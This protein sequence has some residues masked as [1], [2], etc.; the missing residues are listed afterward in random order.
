MAKN[1]EFKII[2]NGLT[3]SI[4]AVDALNKQ[5][6]ALEKRLDT[7]GKKSVSVSASGGGNRAAL[8]EEAKMLQQ[9]EQLHQ[10]V[11][12][13]EKAEYQELLHAK[14][15]LKEYQQIAKSIAAQTNLDQGINNTNTM[16]G[17]KAQLKDLKTAMQ[18]I[19]V[20]SDKFRQM[21]QEANELNTRLKELEQGYGQFGRNVGNYANGVADGMQK[22]VI[23]VGDTARE[24]NNAR[25]ASRTLNMELKSMAL[26]GQQG[27][28][29]YQELNDAVKQM[30]ST[31]K[32]VE[33]SSVAMDNLLDTMQGLTALASAGQGLASLFGIDDSEIEKSIQKMV[34]LQ[35]VLQGIETIRKQMQT[36]EGIGMI[37][38]RG[39]KAVDSLVKSIVGVG[40]ASKGATIAVKLLSGALKGIGIGLVIA[41]VSTL[42]SKITDW[43]EKQEEAKK[44]AEELR[45]ETN[46]NKA[47]LET[48]RLEMQNTLKTLESFNGS[49]KEEERIVKDLNSK[50][51]Q[52]LGTYKTIA[53][54]KDALKKKTDAYI[55]SLELEFEMQQ[56]I[57][58]MEDAYINRQDVRQS[59]AS[60]YEHWWNPFSWGNGEQEKKAMQAQADQA[61]ND[62]VEVVTNLKKKIDEHNEKN[63]INI[64]S[65]QEGN[66]TKKKIKDDS[67]KIEDAV[68]QAENNINDLRLK[69]MRDGLAKSLMQL[70]D[71]NRKEVEKIRKNGQKVEEQLRLQQKVYEQERKKI[72]S[73]YSKE[74]VNIISENQLKSIENTIDKLNNEKDAFEQIRIAFNIPT[75]LSDKLD[76]NGVEKFLDVEIESLK[77]IIA[78]YHKRNE[79]IASDNIKQYYEEIKKNWL[80]TDM[81]G[82]FKEEYEKILGTEGLDAA[83]KK[84]KEVF[85]TYTQGVKRFMTKYG[86]N[87][88]SLQGKGFENLTDVFETYKKDIKSFMSKYGKNLRSSQ[89]DGFASLTVE[90]GRFT[91]SLVQSFEQ[92]G[93]LLD[94]YKDLIDKSTD[95]IESINKKIVESIN[96][97]WQK[98]IDVIQ[99]E[100]TQLTNEFDT[101]S[102]FDFESQDYYRKL[103][104][105]DKDSYTEREQMMIAYVNRMDALTDR[106]ETINADYQEQVKKADF[107]AK[108]EMQETNNRYYTESF[109]QLDNFI[110]KSNE[111]ISKQP[112]LTKLGFID[113]KKTKQNYNEVIGFYE[114]A[115]HRLGKLEMEASYGLT[116]G[117]INEEQFNEIMQNVEY[118]KRNINNDLADI[119]NKS[120]QLGLDLYK[121][122]DQ[123][124]QM[125]G[126]AATQIIQSIGQINDAA[127][128]KEME[129]LD[130]RSEYYEDLLEKQK[131]ITQKY[132]DDVNDIEDELSSSRGDR[133]QYLI[134]MLNQ[135][136]EAQRESLAQEKQI[137][138]EQER[139]DKKRKQLEYENEM[140][141]WNQ[142]KLTAAI[143]AAL[144]ISAAAVNT[145]PMPAIPMIA[146]ATA[147][148]A[149][150]MA[151]VLANKPR[152][153]SEGGMLEGKSHSQGGIKVLGGQ[154]EVEG[155][156][157]VTNKRT[158]AQNLALLQFIN[159]KKRKIDLSDMVDFYMNGANKNISN[160]RKTYLADGGQLPMLRNDINISGKLVTT[161]E[162]YANRDVVVQVVDIINKADNL[163]NTQVLAGLAPKTL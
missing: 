64:Y 13:S 126:Q 27:T 120:K 163:K 28:K 145:W 87:L 153:Y 8:D 60:D 124:L 15:E 77:K 6:D 14:E 85:E 119:T 1:A 31:L 50:Y 81:G 44:A 111:L 138:K 99:M 139:L 37:L 152:K 88:T 19:D 147:T 9:I 105:Q 146:L 23:K 89:G 98:D 159:K 129:A 144:A 108:V 54:W 100:L 48:T 7:L 102:V 140:R 62:A 42:I 125:V 46:K 112:E 68:R 114:K 67:K 158:T 74:T 65:P 137:E 58:K 127:F 24:F 110:A 61:Y 32:D 113:V 79:L 29:E 4:N 109:N 71:N 22:I 91:Q 18:T 132:A 63:K 122:I 162:Q 141:K 80:E 116:T 136:M 69:L 70:D 93:D 83:N 35:N 49:K 160:A 84:L 107:D 30:N 45:K 96:A 43:V 156:E 103:R 133:R 101:N 12:A 3:E 157:Y 97:N 92:N 135:Q 151:A 149:A 21:Q 72:L 106:L 11:A 154:A 95:Y 75:S 2:I 150:Q 16:A 56:A 143:N 86:A 53:E 39:N 115:L 104:D 148:G 25:E 34:A 123:Y 10:K 130:K 26:N 52:A 128:E 94:S 57:K 90:N 76:V 38:S 78:L 17:M 66:E 82:F 47:S 118:F 33:T 40:T 51:G 121:Q 41:A 5:L 131:E 55:E 59:Q 161:M 142:S 134:D 73:D 36:Q 20:D 117:E 155:G